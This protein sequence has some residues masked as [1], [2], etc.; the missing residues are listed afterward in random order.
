MPMNKRAVPK[1]K[2]ASKKDRF[3]SAIND[4]ITLMELEKGARRVLIANKKLTQSVD[5]QLVIE[6]NFMANI[7]ENLFRVSGS[8]VNQA[9][10][11]IHLDDRW[12]AQVEKFANTMV[13]NASKRI[14]LFNETEFKKE[15]M[16]REKALTRKFK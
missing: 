12:E 11:Q 14:Q 4:L 6:I 8:Y 10:E 1:T 3:M 7:L 9:V 13:P 15:L 16:Q 5:M 2:V